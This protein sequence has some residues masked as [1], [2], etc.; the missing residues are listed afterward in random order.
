MLL[1]GNLV[2]NTDY[3][4]S[5]IEN[6][7]QGVRVVDAYTTALN[8]AAGLTDIAYTTATGNVPKVRAKGLEVDGI[9]AG[10]P[11]TQLRFA[12]A[13]TDARYVEFPN[14]AQPNE[15]GYAGE[16]AYRDV[17]GEMLPGSPRLSGSIGA[18]WRKQAFGDKE[19]HV[20][21]NVAYQGKSNSDNALSAYGWIPGGAITDLS[22][23]IGRLNGGFD[24][25]LLAKNVFDEDKPMAAT[26]SGYTP[27][28]PRWFGI[29]VTG[30]L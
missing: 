10:I 29:V 7:Q 8:A 30:E 6:Y 23:G 19:L 9:Y 5:D 28:E 2:L 25:S 16:P 1:D 17:S 12:A 4:L 24:V 26:W 11:H 3:F 21:A 20:S 18:D 22:I 27:R 15:N 13:Y 14:S